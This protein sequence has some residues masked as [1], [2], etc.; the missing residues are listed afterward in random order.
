M[1][2]KSKANKKEKE[3]NQ[4]LNMLDSLYEG[5]L[6]GQA[7]APQTPSPAASGGSSIL[8]QLQALPLPKRKP[9]EE[10]EEELMEL[11]A[12]ISVPGGTN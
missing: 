6:P 2:P 9:L 4:L 11:P 10:D 12:G 5:G 7:P 3:S 8:D 1:L